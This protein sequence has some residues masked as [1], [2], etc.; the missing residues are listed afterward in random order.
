MLVLIINTW[1]KN[2]QT[3]NG[4]YDC[5]IKHKFWSQSDVHIQS[6]FFF[7][8]GGFIFFGALGFTAILGHGTLDF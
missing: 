2:T 1:S 7:G 5:S 4:N 8:G 6:L 3:L